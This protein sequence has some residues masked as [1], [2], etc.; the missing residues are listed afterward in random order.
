M[1]RASSRTGKFIWMVSHCAGMLDLIAFPVWVG[2][3]IG[4]DRFATA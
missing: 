2:T 4:H 3:L 1:V